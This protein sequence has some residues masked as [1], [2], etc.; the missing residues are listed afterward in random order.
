MTIVPNVM[1]LCGGSWLDVNHI[2]GDIEDE[3]F[4]M[5]LTTMGN[6]CAGGYGT[7]QGVAASGDG[8]GNPLGHY[9][10]GWKK[11]SLREYK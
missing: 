9:Y 3:Q 11:H 2:R 10:A 5:V 1:P 8:V 4:Y 6:G 7:C